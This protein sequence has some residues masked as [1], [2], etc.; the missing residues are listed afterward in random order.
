MTGLS[1]ITPPIEQAAETLQDG[2]ASLLENLH[3]YMPD[4]SAMLETAKDCMPDC[5]PLL[6]S[7][8]SYIPDSPISPAMAS[9]YW[10]PVTVAIASIVTIGLVAKAFMGRKDN[11]ETQTLRHENNIDSTFEQEAEHDTTATDA[12]SLV[13]EK[14][15]IPTEI[16]RDL[17]RSS[18]DSDHLDLSDDSVIALDGSYDDE[19]NYSS[20]TPSPTRRS[21]S[22]TRPI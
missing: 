7:A 11:L 1:D 10:L 6:A 9:S 22:P 15:I 20:R 16:E 18:S 13:Q 3:S 19:L 14:G 8:K 2:G 4:S 17:L 12:Q 5:E 21:P